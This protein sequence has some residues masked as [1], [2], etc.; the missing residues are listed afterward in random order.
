MNTSGQGSANNTYRGGSFRG[1]GGQRRGHH[2]GN[3]RGGYRGG[4]RGVYPGGFVNRQP[5][6]FHHRGAPNDTWNGVAYNGTLYNNVP[7]N[8]SAFWNHINRTA[9]DVGGG[10]NGSGYDGARESAYAGTAQA[11]RGSWNGGGYRGGSQN[12]V[13]GPAATQT[14]RGGGVNLR[15]DT[16]PSNKRKAEWTSMNDD[17]KKTKLDQELDHI[18]QKATKRETEMTAEKMKLDRELDEIRTR[19]AKKEP[20]S[21]FSLPRE[22]RQQIIRYVY[23]SQTMPD[24]VPTDLATRQGRRDF[25]EW[26]SQWMPNVRQSA[27]LTLTLA[28]VD[29]RMVDD[30]NFIMAKCAS[31]RRDMQTEWIGLVDGAGEEGWGLVKLLFLSGEQINW[32]RDV[33][34]S[35]WNTPRVYVGEDVEDEGGCGDCCSDEPPD[36]GA[37]WHD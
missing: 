33:S 34:S 29:G 18:Q 6:G 3:F 7:F 31:Q 13:F 8:D 36:A 25:R 35:F 26:Q 5:G 23:E 10:W 22:L 20:V 4:F 19:A 16:F 1:R 28:Q 11:G 12:H 14:L 9:L 37:M 27:E 17:A 2:L 24:A 15:R 32:Y 21:F 30:V